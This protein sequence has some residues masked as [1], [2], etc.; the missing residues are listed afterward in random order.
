[1][2]RIILLGEAL[3]DYLCIEDDALLDKFDILQGLAEQRRLAIW[4]LS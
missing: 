1:M 2:A 3:V 4:V